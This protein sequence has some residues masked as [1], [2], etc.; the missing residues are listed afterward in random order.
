MVCCF[1]PPLIHI[2]S[3]LPSAMRCCN[4]VAVSAMTVVVSAEVSS[5][6]SGCRVSWSKQTVPRPPTLL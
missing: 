5:F 1:T 2:V 4:A 6:G 3:G